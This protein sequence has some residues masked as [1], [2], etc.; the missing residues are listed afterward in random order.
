ME[1]KQGQ[2]RGLEESL[3]ILET[4]K[5]LVVRG[6]A[7]TGKTSMVDALIDAAIIKFGIRGTIVCSAPTHKALAILSGKIHNKK[8]VFS[9]IHSV[10]KYQK[11][12]DRLTG[13][14]SFAPS[15]S[16]KYPP[17]QG[18]GL[19]LI[20]EAS[21]I[22][23]EMQSFIEMYASTRCIVI[24]VGDDKQLNPVG[25][26]DS[27][28]FIGKPTLYDKLEQISDETVKPY[29]YEKLG[30]WV[31]FKPYPQVE[32]TEIIRQGE[33][34]PI[35]TLSRNISLIKEGI[36]EVNQEGQGFLYTENYAKIIEELAA[37]NGTDEW[38]YL[39]WTNSEIDRVNLEVRRRI[40]G[41]EPAKVELGESIIFDAPCGNFTTNQELKI[42]KLDIDYVD[43]DQVVENTGRQTVK[44]KIKLKCYIING[45]KTDDWGDGIMRWKGTFII[46][47]SAENNLKH[48]VYLLSNNCRNRLLDYVTKNEFVN[49]FAKFKYNHAI[50]VH[51]S[52]GST[53]KNTIINVKNIG[54]NSN[55]QEKERLF[56]TGITRAS[57]L[58]IIYN[59]N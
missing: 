51:K 38:K 5:R 59:L 41:N 14:E 39:A 3:E 45:R 58:L 19:L 29:F 57:D 28:V 2:A 37:V 30:K 36:K 12:T 53:Y 25:E 35:I 55:L 54:L 46:H 1:L 26:E 52:Q 27:P 33:G 40:Y 43:F 16:P 24:F 10:L 34:N 7:G 15:F 20:D 42:E 6:S 47:E 31:T 11:K 18:F 4:E 17:M 56:Y 8:V 22:G 9:T 23:L 48:F 49:S 50:T 13:D 32:L 21:M 44:K